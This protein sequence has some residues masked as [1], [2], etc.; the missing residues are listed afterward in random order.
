MFADATHLLPS[1]PLNPQPSARMFAADRRA[2]SA[3]ERVHLNGRDER[4]TRYSLLIRLLQ[5]NMPL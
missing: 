3:S 1:S 2:L 4:R 5:I